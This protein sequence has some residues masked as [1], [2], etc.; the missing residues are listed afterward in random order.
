MNIKKAIFCGTVLAFTPYMVKADIDPTTLIQDKLV[1]VQEEINKTLKTY[2]GQEMNLQQL[3]NSRD[4]LSELKNMGKTFA[5]NY[6]KDYVKRVKVRSFSVKGVTEGLKGAVATPE[7]ARKVG[8]KMTQKEQVSEDVKKAKEH[9]KFI[10]DLQVENVAA[11]YAKSLVLRRAI[12]AENEE[13]ENEEKEEMTDL[14]IIENAYKVV[15]NRA[16]GRW[17]TILDSE[18]NFSGQLATAGLLSIRANMAVEEEEAAKADAQKKA[19][20]KAKKAEEEAKKSAGENAEEKSDKNND[21]KGKKKPN[22]KDAANKAGNAYKDVKS[23]NYGAALGDL[24][25]VAGSTG[26]GEGVSDALSNAGTAY[27]KGKQAKD[28]IESGNYGAAL[29]DLGGVAGA[30]GLGEGVSDALSNAGTVY[31]KGKQ[32]KDNIESGNYGAALGDLSGAAGAAGMGK[33]VSDALSN[34]GTVYDKGKQ[35]KDN[36]ESGNYG[37]ALGDLGGAAGAAGLDE[38]VSNALSGSGDVYNAG[39]GLADNIGS[40]NWSGAFDNVVSG[41]EGVNKATGNSAEEVAK[42]EAAKEAAKKAQEEKL[43]NDLKESADKLQKETFG[44]GSAF[45]RGSAWSMPKQKEKG[46]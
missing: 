33:G 28:N 5:L 35:A 13:L 39:K 44:S 37:A 42:R 20:E 29:G 25:G 40:G 46:K 9:Q 7:M 11:M 18:A 22:W 6:A 45:G 14:S 8:Q 12:I 1:N 30:A 16:V 43:K 17:K 3:V 23:G 26:L 41:A 10:N 15:S 27:D 24:G 2:T 4:K 36:I 34:A 38:D 19:D 32:A 31:D 21:K